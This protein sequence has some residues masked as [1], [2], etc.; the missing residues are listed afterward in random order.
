MASYKTKMKR[1]NRK[2]LHMIAP[3]KSTPQLKMI[4]RHT[5][6]KF[7]DAGKIGIHLAERG[8]QIYH[9]ARAGIAAG[10]ALYSAAAPYL[11]AA[12]VVALQNETFY[13]KTHG[14]VHCF[15]R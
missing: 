6:S 7:L 4:S 3:Y 1:A 15:P 9:T 5:Y 2:L 12:A 13:M 11:G 10:S 14:L 8:L